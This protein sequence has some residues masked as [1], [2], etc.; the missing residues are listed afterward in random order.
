[1]N[2]SKALALS[3]AIMLL[4][5]QGCAI[6]MIE[7]VSDVGGVVTGTPKDDDTQQKKKPTY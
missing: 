6:R 1:M 2:T 3:I 7:G 5:T 4:S